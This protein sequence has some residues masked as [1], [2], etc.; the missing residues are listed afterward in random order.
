MIT[1]SRSIPN[2]ILLL[3]LWSIDI[4]EPSIVSILAKLSVLSFF[5]TCL[6]TIFT[7][8]SWP[9]NACLAF[10][11]LPEEP[12]P[13]VLPSRH[14]PTCVL[15]LFPDIL[16]EVPD[17]WESRFELLHPSLWGADIRL[18]SIFDNG[19]EWRLRR[20]R[21]AFGSADSWCGTIGDELERRDEDCVLT[22][23][24]ASIRGRRFLEGLLL[25]LF[26]SIFFKFFFGAAGGGY[27]PCGESYRIFGSKICSGQV[28]M[29]AQWKGR[30]LT[31]FIVSES[32]WFDFSCFISIWEKRFRVWSSLEK[33]TGK[34]SE[35]ARLQV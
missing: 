10:L 24:P 30:I 29:P 1:T 15:R 19:D 31:S 7:A 34:K 4:W 17:A 21:F 20:C 3:P 5:A 11:T 28:F 22:Q 18:S 23:E 2:G 14:G 13:S 16:V 9:V 33:L 32:S 25:E 8:A 6:L 12:F 35:M 26:R 27:V